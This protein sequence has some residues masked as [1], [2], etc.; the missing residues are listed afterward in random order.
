MLDVNRKVLGAFV[1]GQIL[2]GGKFDSVPEPTLGY[3][4]IGEQTVDSRSRDW[5]LGYFLAL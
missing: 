1:A 4:N 5:L 2:W 3:L